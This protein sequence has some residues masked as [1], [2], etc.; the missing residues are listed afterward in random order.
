MAFPLRLMY[1]SK[2]AKE[3][4]RMMKLL[5]TILAMVTAFVILCGG[6]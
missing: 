6:V 3:V 5:K 4:Y 1:N 2:N